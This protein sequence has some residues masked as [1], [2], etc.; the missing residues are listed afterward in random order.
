M[1][2]IYWGVPFGTNVRWG[3]EEADL[4]TGKTGTVK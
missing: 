3:V 1:Q 4:G 2:D